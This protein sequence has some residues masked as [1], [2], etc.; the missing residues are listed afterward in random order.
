MGWILGFGIP[1]SY[2]VLGFY[3]SRAVYRSRHKRGLTGYY[4][5]TDTHMTCTM[6]VIFWPILAPIYFSTVKWQKSGW[7]NPVESFYKKSLP[8]SDSKKE[9][10]TWEEKNALQSRIRDLE[11]ELGMR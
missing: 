3:L 1:I 10:R 2:F 5:S 4:N 11:Y 7:G 8:E 9:Q 6:M